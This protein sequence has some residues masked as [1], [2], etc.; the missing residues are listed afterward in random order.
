MYRPDPGSHQE[1]LNIPDHH[2]AI[3]GKIALWM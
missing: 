3:E 1:V 2:G